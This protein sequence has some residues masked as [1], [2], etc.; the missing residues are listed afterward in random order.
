MSLGHALVLS[1]PG[2]LFAAAYAAHL[3]RVERLTYVDRPD[4]HGLFDTAN[5]LTVLPRSLE[6]LAHWTREVALPSA[7]TFTP[8]AFD[9]LAKHFAFDGSS[10]VH[11]LNVALCVAA[12]AV[13]TRCVSRAQM[14]RAAPLLVLLPAALLTYAAVICLGRPQREVLDTTYYLYTFSLLLVVLV[15]TLVDF[16]RMAGAT[17]IAAGAVLA[18]FI[19]LHGTQTQDAAK[20]IGRANNNASAVLLQIAAFVDAH[21]AEPDFT[22]RVV[23]LPPSVD[24][25]IALREGYPDDPRAVVRTKRL[26][27]IL[28]ARYYTEDKPKYVF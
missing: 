8:V 5:L 9:R 27:E 22:F 23:E 2:L 6:A 17:T 16:G 26:V 20:A 4:V 12:L 21:K 24:P 1:L 11:L 15:Y 28:F 10:P 19:V 7:L 3:L 18:G 13:A 25:K 14:R